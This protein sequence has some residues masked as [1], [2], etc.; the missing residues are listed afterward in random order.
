M[1][2]SLRVREDYILKVK[3]SLLR[4]GF[5]NQ[6]LLAE[7]LEIAQST[8]S[9]FLNGKTVDLRNFLEICRVLGQEW[10]DIAN[11]DEE[12]PQEEP[13]NVTAKVA[14]GDCC[15]DLNLATML[16]Q[17]LKEAGHEVFMAEKN[18]SWG[19][20]LKQ[21]DYLLLLLS[22]QSAVSEMVLEVVQRVKE[23]HNTTPQKPAIFPIC[24]DLSPDSPL[25]FDLLGYLQGVQAWQWRS[26]D[27]SSTLLEEVNSV[28][29]EGRISLPANHKLAVN[30]Q[31]LTRQTGDKPLPF[32]PP[33]LP[34]GQV[35]LASPFYIERPPIEERC[36][37]TITQPGALIR[38]KAPRQMGKTSLMARIL[39]HAEQRGSRTVAL[40]LQLANQRVFAN[41][42]KF[43][44]WF[45]TIVG[46]ELGVP[47]QLAKYWEMAEIAGSNIS[48]RAYFEQYL[49]PQLDRP[50]TL[51][52]DEVDC[53]FPYQEIADDFFGLLRA[54]HEEAKRR[55]IWKKFRLIVVHSTEVYVPLDM[56]KSP[57]NVGLPIEL[58]EFTSQQVHSL[59]RRHSLDWNAGE[60]EKLMAL[61]GGHPY[62]LR[63]AMYAI[64]RQDV[65]LDQLLQEAPTEAGLYSDHLRRHLWNLEKHPQLMEAMREVAISSNPVRLPTVQAFKL[66]SM[67]LVRLCGNEVTSRCYLYEQ[68]FRER[69]GNKAI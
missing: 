11:F 2:R 36:Y 16:Q 7:H 58:P 35:D 43:L 26:S 32:A 17:A 52:L 57:F 14:L 44:Q 63:L 10:R 30:L 51:G 40:S 15:P 46:L 42:D 68:Y 62:L 28:I 19:A 50:L 64:A 38:I 37:E 34:G 1:P 59:A 61:V 21:C 27:D 53:I 24:I 5:P 55:D 47:D 8:V 41:S 18:S 56:N 25:S 13:P 3:S 60:V 23:L 12:P 4:N 39:H 29:T 69:L 6:R 45:C 66:N 54:L 22:Q 48:C 67:G 33:E 9:N 20:Y 31:T 65:T 49:L